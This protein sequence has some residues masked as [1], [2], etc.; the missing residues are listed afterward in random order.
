[1]GK[2]GLVAVT[3]ALSV[4]LASG[5]QAARAGSWQ[6]ADTGKGWFVGAGVGSLQ[7]DAD[8]LSQDL[9]HYFI[10][11][12]WRFSRLLS[13]DVRAGTSSR[14]AFEIDDEFEIGLTGVDFR[15]ASTYGL[16]ARGIL[17]IGE[18]WDLYGQLGCTRAELKVAI[19]DADQRLSASPFRFRF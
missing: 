4:G 7:L 5:A 2:S 19:E 15:L 1:M 8:G 16:Y 13:V 9:A 10:Q 12:G 14:K 11:G 6:A 18:N 17:P 3:M